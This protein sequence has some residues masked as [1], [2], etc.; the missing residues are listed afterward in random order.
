MLFFFFFACQS[1]VFKVYIPS[2][3]MKSEIWIALSFSCF[4][5]KSSLPPLTRNIGHS[6]KWLD[7][8]TVPHSQFAFTVSPHLRMFSLV[9]RTSARIPIIVFCVYKTLRSIDLNDFTEGLFF[10]YSLQ[11]VYETCPKTRNNYTEINRVYRVSI[12]HT[13][14]LHTCFFSYNIWQIAVHL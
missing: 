8:S 3:S 13:Y 5:K 4:S 1:A 2:F 10:K 12:I 9:L 11:F 6:N 7:V 14:M